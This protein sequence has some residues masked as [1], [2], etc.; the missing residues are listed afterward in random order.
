MMLIILLWITSKW[1]VAYNIVYRR[2]ASNQTVDPMVCMFGSAQTVN[3]AL[4]A[5]AYFPDFPT[6][7]V[8][9]KQNINKFTSG[10]LTVLPGS[11]T[12]HSDAWEISLKQMKLHTPPCQY[13]FA[14]DDDLEWKTSMNDLSFAKYLNVQDTLLEVLR[15]KKPAVAV[16]PWRYG[17]STYASMASLNTL[18]SNSPYQ[19]ATGFDN[20]AVIFHRSIVDFFIPIFLGNSYKAGFIIQHAFLNYFIPYLFQGNA[21]RINKIHYFNPPTTRHSYDDTLDYIS[22]ITHDHKCR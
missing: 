1:T 3:A 2:K 4:Q 14:T 18:F 6:W 7:F 11:N 22:Y 8:I 12:K 17:D 10:N 9:W 13:F 19:P 15:L 21:I 5:S 20:G 16:F